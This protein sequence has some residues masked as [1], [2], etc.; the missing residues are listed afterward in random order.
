M[1]FAFIHNTVFNAYKINKA[2]RKAKFSKFWAYA[3]LETHFSVFCIPYFPYC[4]KIEYSEFHK[5]KDTKHFRV[6]NTCFWVKKPCSEY[7]VYTEYPKMVNFKY[8]KPV[9]KY[10]ILIGSKFLRKT[11]SHS[12]SNQKFDY[13]YKMQ[14]LE[15]KLVIR[16]S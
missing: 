5:T 4:V 11:H 10:R 6:K 12:N 16:G 15:N 7:S 13:D 9:Q 14:G 1:N 3:K 8:P 2:L